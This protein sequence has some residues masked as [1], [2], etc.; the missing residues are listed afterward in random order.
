LA[1]PHEPDDFDGLAQRVDCLPATA[2][3][4]AH[5]HDRVPERARSEAEFD[6]GAAEQVQARRGLGQHRGR[7][8]REVGHGRDQTDA[9]GLGRQDGSSVHVS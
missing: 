8:Q 4:A 1:A 5:G 7:S 3:L 2:P 9:L 6:P